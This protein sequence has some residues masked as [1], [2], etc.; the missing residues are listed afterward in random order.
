MKKI[1]ITKKYEVY[2]FDELSDEAKGCAISDLL[3]M[4]TDMPELY[5]DLKDEIN[6]AQDKVERMY[7]PWFF[8]NYL[9]EVAEEKILEILSQGAYLK[10]GTFF[11]E[12]VE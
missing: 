6:K 9:W 2:E 4:I 10:D 3:M 8:T 11:N 12:G 5:P 7:T 1:T